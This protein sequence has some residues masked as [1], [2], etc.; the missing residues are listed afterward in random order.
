[1]KALKPLAVLVGLGLLA[2]GCRAP[3]PSVAKPDAWQQ[4]PDVKVGGILG[5]RLQLWREHRLWRVVN[6]PFLLKGFESRP[7]QHAWQGEHVGKWLH[8]ATLAYEATHDP[9]LLAALTGVVHR[10][11]A[12]QETNGYLG[13]YAPGKRFYE[14]GGVNQTSWDIWTHRYVLYGLLTYE[15][16]HPN[17]AVVRACE[18]IGDLLMSALGPGRQDLTAIGTREG[19]SSA[20]L[21]ESIMMLYERTHEPRFLDFAIY[22]HQCMERNPRLRVASVL[23]SGGDV[24][25]PGDGKAYQLMAVLLGYGELYRATREPLYGNACQ[26]GWENIRAYHTYVTGGPWSYKSAPNKNR[27]CFAPP[28]FF[29]PAH[30]VENCSTVT[31]I[32]L[33]LELLRITGEARYGNAAERAVLNH[34]FGAQAPN[35][36]DWAYFTPANCPRR[37]YEDRISCCASS[38]P[39]ALEMYARHLLGRAGDALVVNSYLPMQASLTGRW[40]GVERLTIEGNY[41]FD[42]QVTLKLGLARPVRLAVDF[43]LPE[44]TTALAVT[45]DGEPQSLVKTATGFYRLERTW[46]PGETVR[47]KFAFALKAHFHAGRNSENWV[48]FTRG[49]LVL[50]QDVTDPKASPPVISAGPA[51]KDATSLLEPVRDAGSDP[52]TCA[53]RLKGTSVVLVPYYQAGSHGAGVRT[54]FKTRSQGAPLPQ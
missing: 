50:A 25:G 42:D 4:I 13:T 8:A 22:I 49:P 28:E 37:K 1:M 5:Q 10:L 21:L 47:V 16:F 41:P 24:E 6:D 52:M 2:A 34:L 33:C 7:G 40:P 36:N 38:G 17:P 35:G 11:L 39:R 23:S 43:R 14:P 44:D 19:I 51:D 30:V 54:L 32:Q 3:R 26:K 9:K 27:E 31:W 12:A 15:R 48:A 46:K 53:Y 45:I 20:T 18:A 29:D